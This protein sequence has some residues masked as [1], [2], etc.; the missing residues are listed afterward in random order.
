M[1]TNTPLQHASKRNTL[2]EEEHHYAQERQ[3]E[4]FTSKLLEGS[5]NIPVYMH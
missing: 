5:V 4:T 3:Y 2:F 1:E